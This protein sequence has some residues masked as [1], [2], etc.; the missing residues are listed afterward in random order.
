M[1]FTSLRRYQTYLSKTGGICARESLL[2]TYL[3]GWR[4]ETFKCWA[5]SANLEVEAGSQTAARPPHQLL[6][7]R[8][9]AA[10]GAAGASPS[11]R[12]M[13]S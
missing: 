11:C 6:T 8:V 2:I 1:R 3:M 10:V 13:P 12:S 9:P 7:Y 5:A 4:G